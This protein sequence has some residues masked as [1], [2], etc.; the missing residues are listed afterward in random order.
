M[1]TQKKPEIIKNLRELGITQFSLDKPKTY[2]ASLVHDA[3][4]QIAETESANL[5]KDYADRLLFSL[6]KAYRFKPAK[7]YYFAVKRFGKY[8]WG[9]I[10]N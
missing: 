10:S 5:S 9:R 1:P 4:Y 7:I 2:Y 6:L 3:L 8:C